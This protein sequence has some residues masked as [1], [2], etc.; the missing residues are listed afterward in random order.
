MS[1]TGAS[2]APSEEVFSELQAVIIR[3]M[4]NNNGKFFI[5]FF[6]VKDSKDLVNFILGVF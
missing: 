2:E 3:R 1:F 4:R 5:L 6:A